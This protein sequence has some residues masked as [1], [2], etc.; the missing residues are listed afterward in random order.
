VSAF[1]A[2]F[3]PA[4]ARQAVSGQAWLKAMLDAERAL[5][6]A[7]ARLGLVPAA[8]ARAIADACDP[9]GFD[10]DA[11][12]D[13]GRAVGNPAEPLV[14]AL[15]TRVGA[16]DERYVHYGATSQDVVDTA[17]M[18]VARGG[19]AV[20]G[21]RI[22]DVADACAQHAAAHRSTPMVA[23]TL[24][25]QAVPT[26]FGLVASGWLDGTLD[27]LGRLREVTGGLAAQLG[28]AAGTLSVYGE[29]GIALAEQFA[30]ELGL[31]AP[32]LPWH[33]NRVRLAELG[34]ALAVAAGVCGKIGVD[35]VLLAQTEV[36]EVRDASGGG[37]SAMPQKSNPVGAALARASAGLAAAHAGVLTASLVQEHQRAAGAW[38]A[39]WE[40]LC[41]VV[42][43]AAGAADAAARALNALDVDADRMRSNLDLTRGM[44]LSERIAHALA[45]VLG[46]GEAH[47]LL[48][49]VAPRVAG[50]GSLREVL[51]EERRSPLSAEELDALLDPT[52][53]LVSAEALTD[54]ALERYRAAVGGAA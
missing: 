45:P 17:A 41:G 46:R 5:A 42:S 2:L 22:A 40:A 9:T 34:A 1:E 16:E 25:Q 8:A 21:D 12:L 13:D 48:A 52:T 36:G 37:S 51:L 26:T 53:Y 20:V 27:A 38:H 4:A 32:T 33:T 28:G 11:L 30:A 31:A 18:L 49:G 15:R 29:A 54:R 35:I 14:R 44:V 7:A 50:G 3:V 23:R 47:A 43:F 6:A 19:L 24:L 39:E 10:W